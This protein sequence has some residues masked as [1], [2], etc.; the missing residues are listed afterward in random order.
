MAR[1]SSIVATKLSVACRELGR[2]RLQPRHLAQRQRGHG[3][4]QG[5]LE[6]ATRR[7]VAV[8]AAGIRVLDET[9]ARGGIVLHQAASHALHAANAGA[10][11]GVRVRRRVRLSRPI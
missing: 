10:V 9:T 7:Q 2:M 1:D 6:S 3:R 4:R 11:K 5:A 8:A